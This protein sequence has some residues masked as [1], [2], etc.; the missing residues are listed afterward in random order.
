MLAKGV[1]NIS[2]CSSWKLTQSPPQTHLPS[3]LLPRSSSSKIKSWKNKQLEYLWL[4]FLDTLLRRKTRFERWIEPD[5]LWAEHYCM[6]WPSKQLPP[7]A[8]VM[9]KGETNL[10]EGEE[11]AWG[12]GG[13][14]E[15][16]TWKERQQEHGNVKKGETRMIQKTNKK[17]KKNRMRAS[18]GPRVYLICWR[19]LCTTALNS[20]WAKGFLEVEQPIC[21][22]GFRETSWSLLVQIFP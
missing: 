19:L 2:R 17:L 21:S 1:A 20:C 6:Y 14:G 16:A 3:F 22:T 8:S 15:R 12:G 18:Q 7:P 11:V 4:I 5:C 9:H 13:G 10:G